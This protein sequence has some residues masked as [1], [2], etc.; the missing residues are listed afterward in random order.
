MNTSLQ[1]HPFEKA[2]LGCAPFAFEG[3]ST[4]VTN[5]GQPSGTCAFCGTGI[6]YVCHIRSYDGKPSGVG[7]DCIRKLGTAGNTLL[8]EMEKQIATRNAD[9]RAARRAVKM[10]A[11]RE[12]ME[13]VIAERADALQAQ[14][15]RNH[16]F[17][18]E[19]RDASLRMV[20]YYKL[21]GWLIDALRN[22]GGNSAFVKGMLYELH[23]RPLHTLS[24]KATNALRHLYAKGSGIRRDSPKYLAAGDQFDTLHDAQLPEEVVS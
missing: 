7:S 20:K 19:E 4:Q 6:K 15:D 11:K 23:R 12:A 8:S 5:Y 21:N 2:G 24:N 22:Y 18:D 13:R 16:G 10:A 17:T 1:I 9:A 14:R 3:I